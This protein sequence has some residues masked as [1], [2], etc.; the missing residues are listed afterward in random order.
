[1]NNVNLVKY[2]NRKLY[3]HDIKKYVNLKDVAE[4]LESDWTVHV[5]KHSTGEDVTNQAIGEIIKKGYS[6]SEK[7]LELLRKIR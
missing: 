4:L 6:K 2:D 1:M 5:Y 7:L 3:S